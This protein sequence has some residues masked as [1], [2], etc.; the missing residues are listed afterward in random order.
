MTV[1][2]IGALRVKKWLNLHENRVFPQGFNVKVPRGVKRSFIIDI[3]R[4]L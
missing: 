3:K 2:V 1:V 4:A